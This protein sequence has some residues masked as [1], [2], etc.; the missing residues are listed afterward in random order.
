VRSAESPILSSTE[1]IK[2]VLESRLNCLRESITYIFLFYNTVCNC[3]MGNSDSKKE[4]PMDRTFDLQKYRRMKPNFTDD[5]IMSIYDLFKSMEPDEYG[6]VQVDKVRNL[7]R[8]STEKEH[9]QE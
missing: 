5:Q 7:F 3:R 1:A 9:M 4:H 8:K 2:L 6:Q